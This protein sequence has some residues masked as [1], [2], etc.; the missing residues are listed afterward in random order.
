MPQ[1]VFYFVLPTSP[2][3][4]SLQEFSLLQK[5]TEDC[6]SGTAGLYRIRR[7]DLTVEVLTFPWSLSEFLQK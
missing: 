1:A 6:G 3:F 7:A 2:N 5:T 4:N